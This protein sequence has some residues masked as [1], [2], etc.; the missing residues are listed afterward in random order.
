MKYAE[1]RLNGSKIHGASWASAASASTIAIISTPGRARRLGAWARRAWPPWGRA[2]PRAV[3]EISEVRELT[4]VGVQ[5]GKRRAIGQHGRHEAG[6]RDHSA[7]KKKRKRTGD[8]L[9]AVSW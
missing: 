6:G 9:S 7:P 4:K 5:R 1:R 3:S 8:L 2:R